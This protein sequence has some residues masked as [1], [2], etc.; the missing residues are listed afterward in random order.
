[1]SLIVMASISLQLFL[2]PFFGYL[3]DIIGRRKVVTLGALIMLLSASIF[4]VNL[5]LGEMVMSISDSALYAP[6]SS[7]NYLEEN[8]GILRP[9]FHIN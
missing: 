9:V 3:A 2:I 4:L 7:L 1:M 8:I 6:Q 5:F